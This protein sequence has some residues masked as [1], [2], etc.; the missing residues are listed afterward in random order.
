MSERTI[1]RIVKESK[2]GN[3]SNT[4]CTN[5]KKFVSPGKR[6]RRESYVTDLSEYKLAKLVL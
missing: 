2:Y 1:E 5:E 6:R 4:R 3:D